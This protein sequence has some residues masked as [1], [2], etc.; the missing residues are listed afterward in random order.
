MGICA[1][2]SG[3][4]DGVL[5]L[6]DQDVYERIPEAQGPRESGSGQ[7]ASGQT[8][9]SPQHLV[10]EPHQHTT[11][12]PTT[13]SQPSGTNQ[14]VVLSSDPV[15]AVIGEDS[16]DSED[17]EGQATTPADR[18]VSTDL[19]LKPA[20]KFGTPVQEVDSKSE[21]TPS[22]QQKLPISFTLSLPSRVQPQD[23]S[24]GDEFRAPK[25]A[26]D[27]TTASSSTSTT[28]NSTALGKPSMKLPSLALAT[29][30]S[31]AGSNEP[32]APTANKG[33]ALP[34]LHHVV[35]LDQEAPPSSR[36]GGAAMSLSLAGLGRGVTE[37]DESRKKL[38]AYA[39]VLS[40]ITPWLFLSGGF[41]RP[42]IPISQLLGA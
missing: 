36:R 3:P 9:T 30:N 14:T 33:F 17:S 31:V 32:V 28:A 35:P 42:L 16:D 21:L 5:L 8:S 22:P 27:E 34:P 1:S 37:E 20:L 11:P 23:I 41:L 19:P 7:V 6:P 4:D 10:S 38:E 29:A 39:D 15:N 13:E 40:P 12:Q 26:A 25:S 24:E 2:K 18:S